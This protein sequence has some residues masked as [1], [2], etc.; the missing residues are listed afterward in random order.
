MMDF[1]TPIQAGARPVGAYQG[2][3]DRRGGP[4]AV[5]KGAKAAPRTS[6]PRGAR[7]PEMEF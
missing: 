4:E 2:A 5:G 6:P 3:L 7:V 1:T